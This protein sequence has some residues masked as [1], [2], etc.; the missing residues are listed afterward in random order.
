MLEKLLEIQKQLE[1]KQ[2]VIKEIKN[3]T[4]EIDQLHQKH[5]EEKNKS[6]NGVSE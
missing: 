4:K 3:L 6:N 1:E 2:D 5:I